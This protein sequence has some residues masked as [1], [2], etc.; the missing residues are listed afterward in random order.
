MNSISWIIGHL[1][2]QE[3]R[4][5]VA[6]A[7]GKTVVPGLND[8]VGF[9]KPATTPPLA[10]M[11]TA[12]HAITEAADTFLNTLTTARLETFFPEQGGP[13][14]ES[15]GTLLL[16]NIYH[17]WYHTG[18]AHAIRDTLSHAVLPQFVGDMTQGLYRPE[19]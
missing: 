3:Q 4:Y 10:E 16:R 2:N 14:R 13:R 8:L 11:W 5:W 1:A 6:M 7:Q 17:Y 12:W 18:E 15:I 9:G 19:E